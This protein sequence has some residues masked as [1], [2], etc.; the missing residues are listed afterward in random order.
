MIWKCPTNSQRRRNWIREAIVPN[1]LLE[2]ELLPHPAKHTLQ[3]KL[4]VATIHESR[5]KR[6]RASNVYH[7]FACVLSAE[8]TAVDETLCGRARISWE[9]VMS[10]KRVQFN[11][12]DKE[13]ARTLQRKKMQYFTS[14][15]ERTNEPKE[16]TKYESFCRFTHLHKHKLST[17]TSVSTMRTT[18]QILSY[19]KMLKLEKL[20]RF[21]TRFALLRDLHLHLAGEHASEIQHDIFSRESDRIISANA[22]TSYVHKNCTPIL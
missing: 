11:F 2:Q 3:N 1:Q 10:L 16:L 21:N 8:R 6:R 17:T 15:W 14:A 22:H 20:I 9:I 4:V 12:F 18:K 5:C 19:A 7:P 13:V